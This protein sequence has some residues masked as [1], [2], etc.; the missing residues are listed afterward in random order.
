MADLAIVGQPVSSQQSTRDRTRLPD[1]EFDFQG[2]FDLSPIAEPDQMER[3][4]RAFDFPVL[5]VQS[6]PEPLEQRSL[7]R[8]VGADR[9][10]ADI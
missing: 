1:L 9:T 4:G 6:D 8:S 10:G 3:S 5:P 2:A 7:S